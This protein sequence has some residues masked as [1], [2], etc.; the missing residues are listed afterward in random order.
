VADRLG[1]LHN[2]TGAQ[3]RAF[4][5][6]AEAGGF[7]GA[8]EALGVAQPTISKSV[9]A[10]EAKV[11][12]LF[13]RRRGSSVKLNKAGQVLLDM[14]PLIIQRFVQLRRRLD[15]ARGDTVVLRVCTGVYLHEPL[16]RLIAGY[17]RQQSLVRVQLERSLSRLRALQALRLGTVDAAFITHFSPPTGVEPEF[18]HEGRVQLYDSPRAVA[19]KGSQRP[20]I[21]VAS[22]ELL[23]RGQPD[24]IISQVPGAFKD[25]LY[26]PTYDAAVRMCRDG[27]GR[28]YVFKE[29][30]EEEVAKGALKP[31]PTES[32][33]CYRTCHVL[34]D[35]PLLLSF[36]RTAMARLA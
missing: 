6:V 16:R 34:G 5:V 33:K 30:A 8:A 24:P 31:V 23:V 32:I 29:D 36:A 10:L 35:D 9:S 2:I 11:G 19:S 12:P 26:A 20:L 18:V 3:L 22:Q 21:L 15:A 28:T 1:A 4:V 14:A 7:S 25:V 17:H 27:V 13:E